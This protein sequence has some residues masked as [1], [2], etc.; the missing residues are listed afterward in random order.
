M[1]LINVYKGLESIP[2]GTVKRLRIVGVPAKTHPTMNRPVMGITRDDPGKFV[3]G[4]VPVER[5]GSAYFRVP[6]GVSFFLQALDWDGSAVQTMRSVT[7]VQPGQR[8]TC[9]GC[10]EPRHTAPPNVFPMAAAREPSKITPGPEGS[11]PLDFQVLV[12][13]VMERHCVDCHQ[14]GGADPEFDLT[15]AKSYE[16]LVGYGSPSLRAHVTAR[17]NEGRSTAGACAARSNSLWQ[18]LDTGHYH[19]EL[20]WDERRRLVTWMDTYGQ[21]LGSFDREQEKQLRKLRRQMA[22]MLKD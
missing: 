19:V 12:Q 2:Q 7:Y 4:T 1:L 11:W 9:I 20:S 14:P 8:Y 22:A 21:R 6:A 17:Y 3:I 18:L 15:A 13:P 10:H 5:D 16:S